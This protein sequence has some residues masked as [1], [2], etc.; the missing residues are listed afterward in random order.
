[1]EQLYPASLYKLATRV[2]A[3]F[4]VW[5]K[6]I[7]LSPKRYLSRSSS[8]G[9]CTYNTNHKNVN[10]Q[11]DD[12]GETTSFSVSMHVVRPAMFILLRL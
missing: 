5:K 9:D 6:Y 4:C 3:L 1:M 12:N 7:L 2:I 8:A 11:Y 10:L